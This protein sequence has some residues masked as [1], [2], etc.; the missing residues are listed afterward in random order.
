MWTTQG[1]ALVIYYN[2]ILYFLLFIII[3]DLRSALKARRQT[4]DYDDSANTF[5]GSVQYRNNQND[6]HNIIIFI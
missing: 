5:N 6:V 4:R 3:I 1:P 2:N